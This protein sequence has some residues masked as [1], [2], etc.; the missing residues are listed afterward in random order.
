MLKDSCITKE[1]V[2]KS[3]NIKVSK[4]IPGAL[5]SLGHG[6]IHIVEWSGSA[7]LKFNRE[8]VLSASE[9]RVNA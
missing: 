4:E 5:V 2:F 9:S 6:D 3:E 1:K 8:V 7:L